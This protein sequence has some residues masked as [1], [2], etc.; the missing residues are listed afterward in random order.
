MKIDGGLSS[1][2]TKPRYKLYNAMES[3]NEIHRDTPGQE[4]ANS[5]QA[6]ALLEEQALQ[7]RIS[8]RLKFANWLDTVLSDEMAKRSTNGARFAKP[9]ILK[10]LGI[11]KLSKNRN[12]TLSSVQYPDKFMVEY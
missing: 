7:A 9:V 12:L 11:T 1:E 3:N 10:E 2:T 8:A 6:L 4:Q 5:K